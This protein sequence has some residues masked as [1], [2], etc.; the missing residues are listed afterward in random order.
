MCIQ[1]ATDGN[2]AD[3]M[4]QNDIQP[5]SP[6]LVCQQCYRE[7][8]SAVWLTWTQCLKPTEHSKVV[9]ITVILDHSFTTLVYVRE[10]PQCIREVDHVKMCHL[11]TTSSSLQPGSSHD[12]HCTMAHSEEEYKYW[13]WQLAITAL[14][15]VSE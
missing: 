10:V 9:Q 13:K 12:D 3:K 11:S 15:T 14:K 1:S 2:L 7:N 4:A 8:P 6:S 5:M